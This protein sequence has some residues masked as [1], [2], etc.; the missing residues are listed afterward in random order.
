MAGLADFLAQILNPNPGTNRL[1]N[2]GG[3]GGGNYLTQTGLGPEQMAR[4]QQMSGMGGAGMTSAPPVAAP[5]APPGMNMAGQ[6]P[7]MPP[8]QAA[9]MAAPAPMGGGGGGILSGLRNLFGGGGGGGMGQQEQINHTINWLTTT[10]GLDPGTAQAI[11]VNPKLLQDYLSDQMKPKPRQTAM[12]EGKLIDT[13][14]GEV[15]GDYGGGEEE[16]EFINGKDGSIFK[17]NKTRGSVEQVY[18]GKPE[19]FRQLTDEEEIARK[20]DPSKAWQVGPDDRTYQIGGD[21]TTVNNNIDQ[22]AEGAFEKKLAELDAS[23]YSDMAKGGMEAKSDLGLVGELEGLLE[24]QGGMWTGIKGWAAQRGVDVGEST[25]DL[26]AAQALIQKMVPTQRSA[27][28]GSMSDRDVEMYTRSLP[29]LLN[30][31]E[32]NQKII[33]TMKGLAQYKKAQGDI[34]GQVLSGKITRQKARDMLMAL[35]NP[36]AEF[37][38]AKTPTPG[39]VDP[40]SMSGDG[41]TFT[42]DGKRFWSDPNNAKQGRV[43]GEEWKPAGI[44]GVTVRRVR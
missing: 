4:Y 20:L 21:G 34:S 42:P 35:P 44:P 37:S 17:A 27:G 2:P 40:S 9:P 7:M 38:R 5:A 14:T 26:Q 18:G 28:S 6:A 30:T 13:D 33:N 39:G 23:A 29:A 43:G 15:I 19:T 3:G 41:E 31:P 11:A 36:L 32:G 16:F 12:F 22:R 24:G 8:A 25:S 1:A 10:K